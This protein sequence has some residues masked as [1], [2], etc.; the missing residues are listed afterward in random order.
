MFEVLRD[1]GALA[2]LL[3]EVDR[4]WGVPQPAEH[5]PEVDTGVHLMMVL[6]MARAAAAP[7]PVRFACL[8]TTWARARRRRR[9]GRAT[10]ATRRAASRWR[11]AGR[12]LRVPADCRELA[13][14]VAREHGNVHRSRELDAAALLRLLE[15]CDA[16]RRPERFD[17][18]LLACECDARGRTGREDAP[19]RSAQ[20]LRAALRRARW[21]S[22]PRAVA[23]QAAAAR[24]RRPGD[25]RGR[26]RGAR[27]GDRRAAEPRR[28]LTP[29]ARLC[30]HAPRSAEEAR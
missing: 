5:H 25:R 11:G 6:D 26:A 18:L 13:E 1:C 10:S 17:E 21:R 23:A 2:R 16:L 24:P 22:T 20:R 7:L 3:P 19:T 28:G 30:H 15:R 8:A 29:T 27:A 4:L 14:V 9:A 12:A